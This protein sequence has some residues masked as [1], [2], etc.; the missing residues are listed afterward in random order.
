MAIRKQVPGWRQS[1][2]S[3]AHLSQRSEQA[4]FTE[5]IALLDI[6]VS[7][8]ALDPGPSWSPIPAKGQK[9]MDL[10]GLGKPL[11]IKMSCPINKQTSK[12]QQN[13]THSQVTGD[14][15]QLVEPV[16]PVQTMVQFPS[17]A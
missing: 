2:A 3:Y 8:L 9:A 16:Q 7:S 1:I 12:Q 4:V 13:T 11:P 17:T 10:S 6:I 14:V 15:V 5:V